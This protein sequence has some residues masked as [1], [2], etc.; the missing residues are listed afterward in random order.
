[1]LK[2]TIFITSFHLLIS[3]NIIDTDITRLLV[4]QQL[5][6][7]VIIPNYKKEYFER[8]FK[9]TGLLFEGVAVNE[10]SKTKLGL[11]FKRLARFMLPTKTVRL[12]EKYRM[13]TLKKS[14]WYR[15]FFWICQALGYLTFILPLIRFLDEKYSPHHFFNKLL[16]K[17]HP[18]L[19]VTTD[20]LNENDVCLMQ[21][22][23]NR[24][25]P[26]V[27]VIR[28]WDNLT[29]HSII[30]IIPDRLLVWSEI[31]KRE[32][33]FYGGM[34]KE[35]ITV[36]GIPHF[37]RYT[38]DSMIPRDEFIKKI[39][40]DPRKKLVFFTPIGDLYLR[41][42]DTDRYVLDLLSKMD[43]NILVRFPAWD[44]VSNMD[45][46]QP[47]P[48]MFFDKPGVIHRPNEIGDRDI[49]RKD[50]EMLINGIYWSDLVITGPSTIAIEAAFFDKPIVLV[51]FH[52]T[53]KKGLD[54]IFSYQ[55][56]HFKYILKSGGVRLVNT[57]D[58]FIEWTKRYL[59]NPALDQDGRQRIVEEQF[60]GLND[61]HASVRIV[62]AI[63]DELSKHQ[64]HA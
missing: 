8:T 36:V 48:H 9:G 3:R 50:N 12:Y 20:I 1:M 58:E 39:G 35:K 42:N 43:V 14:L 2:K 31:L 47:P 18:D 44:K 26:I 40:A 7:V 17:Y 59:E 15:L 21:E 32:A 11:F 52:Q 24:K 23:K 46:F 56:N 19:V 4:A 38:S 10:P 34:S 53:H 60:G 25:I 16:D 64:N 62:N 63:I 49:S 37:D 61:H 27:A 57:A 33:S 51:N 30:R 45:G 28:S 29:A 41:H 5:R 13:L 22:A 54:G 6:V 55:C